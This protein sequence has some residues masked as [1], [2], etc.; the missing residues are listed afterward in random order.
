MTDENPITPQ[1][2]PVKSA[3]QVAYEAYGLSYYGIN[4]QKQVAAT[5][6]GEVEPK[7]RDAWETAA[8]AAIEHAAQTKQ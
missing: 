8:Q 4:P 6:W 5:A 7:Q 3:G 1:N 2:E